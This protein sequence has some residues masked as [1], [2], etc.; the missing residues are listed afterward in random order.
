MSLGEPTSP[1][2]SPSPE[3]HPQGGDWGV[4]QP[5]G[6]RL[7]PEQI[8]S[9]YPNPSQPRVEPFKV[10]EAPAHVSGEV[11][12]TSYYDP[13]SQAAVSDYKKLKSGPVDMGSGK[14]S[15]DGFHS[16]HRWQQV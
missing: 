2:P 16:G 14:L 12:Q 5:F 11:W 7:S 1:P 13:R 3:H 9:P 4:S 6:G 8:P 15:D 10:I